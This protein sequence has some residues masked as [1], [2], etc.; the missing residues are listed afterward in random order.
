[1]FFVKNIG[2]QAEKF[3]NFCENVPLKY[4]CFFDM[5]ISVEQLKGVEI[6]DD[7]CAFFVAR[8]SFQAAFLG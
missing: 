6:H 3:F 5:I 1:M 8:R 4:F 7:F 2:A